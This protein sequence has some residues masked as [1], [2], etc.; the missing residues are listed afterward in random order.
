MSPSFFFLFMNQAP[1]PMARTTRTTMTMIMV[2]PPSSAG[3]AGASP[4][5]SLNH[6][7]VPEAVQSKEV[8]TPPAT[9][10]VSVAHSASS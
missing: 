3:A 2:E 8:V 1:P 5:E 9:A 6:E 7:S 4:M 10:A